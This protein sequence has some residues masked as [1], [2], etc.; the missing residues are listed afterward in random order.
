[1]PTIGSSYGTSAAAQPIVIIGGG[2]TGTIMAAQLALYGEK[3]IVLIERTFVQRGCGVA[4]GTRHPRH[5]LNVRAAGMSAFP[6]KPDHF[7]NWLATRRAATAHDF[8]ERGLYGDYLSDVLE[9]A[10][11]RAD[12]GLISI[13]GEA[14]AIERGADGLM[15]HLADGRTVRAYQVV[16]AQ[17][18]LPPARPAWLGSRL[19]PPGCYIDDPWADDLADH[20]PSEGTV[21][22]LGSG[23]TAVDAA[24]RLDA[25]GFRGRILCL[26]RRGLKPHRHLS[27]AIPLHGQRTT[28]APVLSRLVGELRERATMIGWHAA[29]DE[30]RPVTQAL[31]ARMPMHTR[32]RFLRH[33]RPYWD[34]HRHRLA[35]VVADRFDGM[36][37]EGRVQIAAGRVLGAEQSG[38]TAKLTWDARDDGSRHVE[39]AIAIINCTGPQTDIRRTRAPLLDDLLARSLVRPDPLA[40]GIDVDQC[41]RVINAHGE[42]QDDL[43]CIGPMS[44]G[45]FWEIIA[46]PDIR[47]QCQ[48]LAR[49]LA[50]EKPATR[51]VSNF[52]LSR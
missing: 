50:E 33:L 38:S 10:R 40:L 47:W 41:C 28:P 36:I 4:F 18:N 49:R 46:I 14:T 5:M 22:V 27:G 12:G 8:V 44:R 13:T 3:P 43:F 52:A 31:W 24:L 51:D 17:G 29:V 42:A 37:A 21:V 20:L 34:I 45:T 26:S 32:S 23:L 6:D 9:Q 39:D 2:P 1:M 25:G 48:E 19:L 15:V 16:L 30:L 11:Y 35:P 7:S